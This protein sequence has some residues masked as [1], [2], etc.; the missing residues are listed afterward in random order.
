MSCPQGYFLCLVA[1]PPSDI[2]GH[3]LPMLGNA[4]QSLSLRPNS[5]SVFISWLPHCMPPSDDLGITC[6]LSLI[7]LDLAISQYVHEI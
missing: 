3:L 4:K 6:S 2:P 7:Y 1:A 5:L